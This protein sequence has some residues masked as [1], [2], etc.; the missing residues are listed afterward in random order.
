MEKRE[1]FSSRIGFIF[2]T[3]GCAIGLGNV[4]RFPFIVGKYGGGAFVLLYL[5]FLV[6]LGIPVMTMELTVGRAG[7]GSSVESFRRLE[8]KG[9]KWHWFGYPFIWGNYILMMF[10]TTVTGWM[11]AYVFKML[12]SADSKALFEDTAQTFTHMLSS[13]GAMFFWMVLATFI[14]FLVVRLGL[15]NGVE[16]ITK[17]M[18]AGLFV[19]MLILA[20]RILTLPGALEGVYFYL[21]PDF[22]KMMEHGW[23]EVVFAALGQA[24]F[25][26]SIGMSAIAIF[27]SYIDKSRRLG[28]EA[29]S[30]TLLDTLV[31][32]LAG[33]IV[34]PAAFVFKVPLDAGPSLVFI[35]LPKI[36]AKMPLGFLWGALFFLFMSFAALSTVIAVFENIV[37]F[38]M[39]TYRW[40][41]NKAV[42]V[43]M[44]LLIVLS[45][46]CILGFNRWSAF[47]PLGEGTNIL[48]LE[49][50]LISNTVLPLGSLV[51]IFFAT[52]KKGWG[53][54]GFLKEANT[55][56]GIKFP[57]GIRVYLR[58]VMP[59]II[60]YIFLQGYMG[61][62]KK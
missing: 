9:Q 21:K 10:Y 52:A 60:L 32:L 5:L 57:E 53:W 7:Q 35:T 6:I 17:R 34:V 19:I 46:P 27:G 38:W 54:K 33:L 18:M 49:D 40:K 36:F 37:A 29:L 59:V 42:Y 39:D 24:F 56:E 13:P 4:W 8:A 43:N 1:K 62:F 26:L 3:A 11:M 16:K 44:L 14:G 22:S 47:Q 55:G 12:F 2:I 48:D 61:V 30:I 15:K 20:V 25:T 23:Q 31:A 45:V 28:G 51:Y 41:R 58:Y 50:L